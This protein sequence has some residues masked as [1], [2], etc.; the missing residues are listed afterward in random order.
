MFILD[1]QLITLPLPFRC[2]KLPATHHAA[3]ETELNFAVPPRDN[4][5]LIQR[6]E[7]GHVIVECGVPRLL[8]PGARST[9]ASGGERP[10]PLPDP[11]IP[12]WLSVAPPTPVLFPFGNQGGGHA[13]APRVRPSRCSCFAVTSCAGEVTSLWRNYY[14]GL[15]IGGW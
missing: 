1:S 15:G 11:A 2:T 12:T 7:R 6:R 9:S 14:S 5:V 3:Q 10:P 4:G 8:S 13:S